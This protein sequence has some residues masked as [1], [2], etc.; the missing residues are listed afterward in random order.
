MI[1]LTSVWF[2]PT[3]RSTRTEST[4]PIRELRPEQEQRQR[5]VERDVGEDPGG[6][7]QPEQ[8][9]G[10][11]HRA[12]EHAQ[13]A[14]RGVEPDRARQLGRADEVVQHQLLPR[15]PQRSGQPVQHQ[16][17]AGLPDA[18]RTGQEQHTPGRGHQHEQRLRGLD[19]PAAVVAVGERPEIDAE[20]QER[21]PVADHLE[22]G[23]RR[24]VELLPQHPVGDDVLDV[25]GH[26]RQRRAEEIGPAV[27]VAQRGELLRYGIGGCDVGG[28]SAGGAH[29]AY[30]FSLPGAIRM[31]AV[32]NVTERRAPA[33]PPAPDWSAPAW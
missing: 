6:R 25:V 11:D 33:G 12:E 5:Q 1:M 24:R 15:P 7:A 10:A 23:Q 22:A 31:P 28:D 3:W 27:A 16:Q 14:E 4:M 29:G 32:M 30:S 2:E 17:Q 18:Q 21:H 19:H 13:A 9:H 26:H 8:Q 20:Q